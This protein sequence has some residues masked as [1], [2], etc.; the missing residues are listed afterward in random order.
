MLVLQ[1]S[2]Q[3]FGVWCLACSAH[4]D[5]A[6]ADNRPFVFMFFKDF[7][8]EQPIAQPHTYSVQPRE[9]SQPV[10]DMDEV[11]FHVV[12][13]QPL[14]VRRPTFSFH[15]PIFSTFQ[16]IP[17]LCLELHLHSIAANELQP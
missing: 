16:R 12:I 2:Y 1:H 4:G 14:S 3:H 7:G 6:Y 9:W 13:F 5:I 15:F 10:V 8:V 17:A 11:A